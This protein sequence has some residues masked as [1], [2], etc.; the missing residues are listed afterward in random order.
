MTRG[1]RQVHLRRQVLQQIV[2][3]EVDGGPGD[4]MQ[5]VQDESKGVRQGL[6]DVVDQRAN[7]A[8]HLSGGVGGVGQ[9]APSCSA[10]SRVE[11]LQSG[12]Q[13][14]QKKGRV[15]VSFIQREPGQPIADCGLP[16]A[17]FF[18]IFPEKPTSSGLS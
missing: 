14:N 4:E 3:G 12:D 9:E 15:V 18:G 13:V 1:Y 5:V 17:D 8:P 7:D 2:Q 6:Q 10:T 11:S 16:I